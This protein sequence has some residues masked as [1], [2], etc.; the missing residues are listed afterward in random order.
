MVEKIINSYIKLF[1]IRILHHYWLDYG[2]TLFDDIEEERKYKIISNYNCQ[3]IFSI[4]PTKQTENIL[5][6]LQ[7][8]Y[9]NTPFGFIV[10]SKK[11]TL[12][13]GKIEFE[14]VILSK[15]P[16]LFNYTALTLPV[17]NI[18]EYYSQTKKKKYRYK[19]N[20][21]TLTN[22]FGCKNSGGELF[23]SQ[24]YIDKTNRIE[25]FF[26]DDNKLMQNYGNSE[27]H[28][29]Y[30]E[31]GLKSLP[32]FVN[33]RDILTIEK[34]SVDDD[35]PSCKGIMLQ[36]GIPDT[37]F[38]FIR[39]STVNDMNKDFSLIDGEKAKKNAPIFQIR[40]KNRSTCWKYID[41]KTGNIIE[42][43][44]I[45]PLTHFGNAGIRKK[46]SIEGIPKIICDE[47]NNIMKIISDIYLMS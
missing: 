25:E 26:I 7:C 43:T 27:S 9:K 37:I 36:E 16:Y 40:L 5:S 20:V 47:N 12:F 38:S 19:E 35:S 15:D 21:P 24:E 17:R 34:G 10:L 2:K 13:K 4:F 41:K 30:P 14:F 46:P 6:G 18:F 32:I 23:L 3:R 28:V 1:E 8:I 33:Q 44:Q 11:D 42:E 45:L 39:I 31:K 22:I 29:L